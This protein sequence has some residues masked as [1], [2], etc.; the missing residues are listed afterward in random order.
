M[1]PLTINIECLVEN[2][3][4]KDTEIKPEL[5]EALTD[6][7]IRALFSSM[8]NESREIIVNIGSIIKNISIENG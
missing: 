3:T 7:M 1:K 4:L 8:Q 2:Y 6:I 5:S